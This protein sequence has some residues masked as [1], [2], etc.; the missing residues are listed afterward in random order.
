[1]SRDSL[2][3]QVRR[4]AMR[5]AGATFTH[6][7]HEAIRTGQPVKPV[8]FVLNERAQDALKKQSK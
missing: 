3:R 8:N 5:R 4:R 6:R 7:V 2:A 1:M